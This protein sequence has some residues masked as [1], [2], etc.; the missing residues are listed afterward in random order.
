MGMFPKTPVFLNWEKHKEAMQG[1][2]QDKEISCLK[3]F[4]A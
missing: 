2:I 4:A 1:F 3:T